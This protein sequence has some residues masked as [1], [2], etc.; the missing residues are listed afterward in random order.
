MG[1]LDLYPIYCSTSMFSSDFILNPHFLDSVSLFV[2]GSPKQ[3]S[4]AKGRDL[5]H[6]RLLL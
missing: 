5:K 3:K 1:D 4:D 2:L 6:T